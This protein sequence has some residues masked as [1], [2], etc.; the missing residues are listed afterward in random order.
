MTATAEN[1]LWTVRVGGRPLDRGQVSE[2][3]VARDDTSGASALAV[4]MAGA[5]RV[6][7]IRDPAI[8]DRMAV[9]TARGPVKRLM[10][11]R[12]TPQVALGAT[13]HGLVIERMT[14]DITVDV[15][16]DIVT[17]SRPSGLAL[18]APAQWAREDVAQ[19]TLEYK[20]AAFPALMDM[21]NWSKLPDSGPMSGFLGRYN[22]LQQQ[23]ADEADKGI[24]ATTGARLSLARFLVGQG[25]NFEAIG[26]LDLLAKQTPPVLG[27]AQFRGLRAMAKIMAGRYRDAKADLDSTP[28]I[29]DPAADL[30]RGY[31]AVQEGHFADARQSF[32]SGAGALDVFPPTWRTR[33]AA[34]NA[35]A[36]YQMNDLAAAKDIIS[37]AVSQNAPPLE[38]LEAQLVQAQI[39]EGMGDKTRALKM[40]NAIAR[41]PLGRVAVPAQLRAA[42]LNLN[43]GKAKPE[44]TLEDLNGLRYRWRGDDTELE[45]ISSIGDI[46]LG[47]G[48]YRQALDVLKSGGKQFGSRPDAVQIQ[49]KLSTAF[50]GLFL[51][52]QADGLQPIEALGL[53]YDFRDLTPVGADGDDMVRRLAR[54]LMDVD[55]L[56]QAADLLQYQI[57]NRL[58]GVA[59]S[60]VA[61]DV[62]A[63]QLMNRQ[64]E[65]ALQALWKTRTSLLPKP[66]MAE[67]RILE[68]RALTELGRTDHALEVLG[69]DNSGDAMDIRA[70][71]F[72]RDKDWAKAG[73]ML[74]RRLGDRWKRDGA[75]SLEDESRLIRAGVAYSLMSDQRS[76]SRL[77][78][79]FGKF[80]D[81][82][83]S[84]EAVNVALAGMDNGPINAQDFALAASKADSF[85]G[86]VAGMKKRL[87]DK[88]AQPLPGAGTQRTAANADAKAPQAG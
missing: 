29:N 4:N 61:A 8:G 22:Q 51:D 12:T 57:D 73:A 27:D 24:G 1:G 48:R 72:W 66:V 41:A 18:S 63:I 82:A 65:K 49:T 47:Q 36:A 6:A 64:P 5:S 54:R 32:K 59:K 85:T 39:F 86:W 78:D 14:P 44:E 35:T 15:S 31:V 71:I 16:G 37:Y 81:G 56:D 87:R 28:L 58:Q 19:R 88:T 11:E 83:Q 67:R 76:L 25:L 13:S 52:G 38:T 9:V 43:L 2:V 17:V 50:R 34:A 20:P 74:E 62:A 69:T 70:D 40:Y 46:Y 68:A 7:W 45:L 33:F 26:V 84:P 3:S 80:A 21:D 75:L 42:R 79:R 10:S 77:T 53:F 60:S 30:W 55:L 23:A